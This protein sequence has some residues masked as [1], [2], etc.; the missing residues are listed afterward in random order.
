MSKEYHDAEAP[1]LDRRRTR[2]VEALRKE[3]SED[4]S[5]G[6]PEIA[7]WM[8]EEEQVELGTVCIVMPRRPRVMLHLELHKVVAVMENAS[9]PEA[10]VIAHRSAR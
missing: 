5:G 7:T 3:S 4:C 2:L 10:F 6:Y 9:H 1:R 8:E